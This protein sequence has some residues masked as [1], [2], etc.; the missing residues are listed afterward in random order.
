MQQFKYYHIILF[1]ALYGIFYWGTE[2]YMGVTVPG[3]M[4]SPW[5]DKHLDYVQA[6]RDFL[7]HASAF[8]IRLFGKHTEIGEFR[9]GINHGA[10][11]RL[12]YSCLG[13]AIFSFWW[14][15]ILAFPQTMK[16][17]LKYFFGGTFVIIIMNIIRIVG[18]AII[19]TSDW[20][21]AHQNFDHH[22][23]FN[24]IV[25]GILFYMLYKWFNIPE[26]E[27]NEDSANSEATLQPRPQD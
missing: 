16:N 18:V 4:Y 14:A 19:F 15:M 10:G 21:R 24:I 2:F 1:L 3:G 9:V 5:L 8:F 27:V 7:L 12:V 20:G 6:Y 22:L 17:K 13:F 23:M 11:V 25:Y 26:K